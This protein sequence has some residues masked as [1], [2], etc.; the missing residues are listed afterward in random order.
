MVLTL[1]AQ[2]YP[3]P[4]SH[5]LCFY[6][7][8]VSHNTKGSQRI[9]QR[10]YG[11]IP[12]SITYTCKLLM[13]QK[14]NLAHVAMAR[15][16]SYQL[17]LFNSVYRNRDILPRRGKQQVC[18]YCIFGV[19]MWESCILLKYCVSYYFSNYTAKIL[20]QFRLLEFQCCKHTNNPLL[21][22]VLHLY[23]Q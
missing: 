11:T 12:H 2:L 18:V 1:V 9:R 22:Q 16:S 23:R 3:G 17:T 8:A 4:C 10:Q 13:G 7:I 19:L 20:T 6:L 21:D 5:I 14:T 15:W